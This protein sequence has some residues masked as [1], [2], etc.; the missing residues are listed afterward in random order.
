VA[1]KDLAGAALRLRF[2]IE[3]DGD[4]FLFIEESTGKVLGDYPSLA[5]LRQRRELRTPLEDLA[6]A[7][8]EVEAAA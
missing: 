8:D 7:L 3:R 6:K 5:E 2:R 4:R 1:K